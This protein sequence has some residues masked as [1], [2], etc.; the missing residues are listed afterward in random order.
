MTSLKHDFEL[1][2][3]YFSHRESSPKETAA[4][5]AFSA[6]EEIYD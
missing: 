5:F 1:Y 6:A 2:S 3:S 4:E